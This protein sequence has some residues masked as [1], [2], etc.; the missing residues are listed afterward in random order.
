MNLNKLMTSEFTEGY[1]PDELK[2]FLIEFR[3]N[4]R[5][6]YDKNQNLERELNNR[7]VI[8][9]K[10]EDEKNEIIRRNDILVSYLNR[11]KNLSWK[12]RILGKTNK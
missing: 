11:E 7:D 5:I 12:E 8:I 10:M 6:L 4:Y 2:S 9:N 1:N 3:K